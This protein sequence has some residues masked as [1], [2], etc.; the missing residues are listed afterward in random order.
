MTSRFEV[1]VTGRLP[2]ALTATIPTR[3][4]EVVLREQPGS[5]VLNGCVAD[6]AFSTCW[7][8]PSPAKQPFLP[9]AG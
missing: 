4:G 2:Q 5:T 8:S 9:D 7:L 3:F 1:H 6:Q